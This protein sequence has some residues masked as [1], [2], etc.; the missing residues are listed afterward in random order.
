MNRGP[1]SL[2]CA[3]IFCLLL[4]GAAWSQ[5]PF[6]KGKT[7]RIVV[8]TSAGGG[9]DTYTRTIVRH[10]GKF[11]PGNPSL[12]VENMPGAGHLIG[13]NH[14]YKVAKPDGL[15]IGHFHGGLFLYQRLGRQGIDFDS[16]KFRFIGAPVT[17][18]RACAFT[19]ASGI[20]SVER[21]LAAKTPVK[22]GGI[23]GGATE[24]I[25][26]MLAATT[27][28]PIQLVSGYKGT[29]EIRL[30]AESGE[31]AGG[32]WTWDSIR[33]TW[34]K[35]IQSGDA[36]VVLQILSKPHPELP[37]VPLASKL[38]KNDEARQ[39]IQ[40]GIEEPSD[41]YRP[42]VLPPGT[43][44]ERVDTLRKA[45]QDTLKDPEFLADARKAKLDIEPITGEEMEN[46]VN[47]LFK[48]SPTVVVKLREILGAK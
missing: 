17:D 35:A 37:T 16:A 43:P 22:V 14:I 19:R 47:K 45:F 15:T 4:A 30:A 9:F 10:M 39:L 34:T 7:I 12:V 5:E 26:R 27:A 18:N 13:A 20:T 28:L 29:S 6:Y 23:G 44:K 8:A 2:S 32:C 36:V 33:A 1:I 11:I 25:P 40:L 48:L 24:D 46:K 42:Y 21:W 3:I 41:Y 31:L 38:A